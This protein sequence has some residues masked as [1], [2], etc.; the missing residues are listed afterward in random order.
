MLASTLLEL[1]RMRAESASTGP[2]P[3]PLASELEHSKKG[4]FYLSE[5]AVMVLTLIDSLPFLNLL[6]LEEWLLL[7]AETLNLITDEAIK[8]ICRQRFW[9]VLSSGE[10]DVNR[11]AIC[12]SWWSTNGGRGMVLNGIEKTDA[13]SMS[14]GLGEQSKL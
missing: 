12:V 11:A 1:V 8:N 13:H 9:E 3:P 5:Q 6:I 14:G 7:T 4:E 10:M 2:L